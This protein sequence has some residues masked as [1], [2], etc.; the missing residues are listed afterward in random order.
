[1]ARLDGVEVLEQLGR[2]VGLRG[3]ERGDLDERGQGRPAASA[4]TR[5]R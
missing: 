4:S 5:A 2:V 3:V 1:V